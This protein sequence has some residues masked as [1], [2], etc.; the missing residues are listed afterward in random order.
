MDNLTAGSTFEARVAQLLRSSTG[1]KNIREQQHIRGMNV[2][3]IF[4]KQWN[5]HRYLTI[6]V[7]CKNWKKGL[8]RQALKSIYFDYEPLIQNKDIDELWIITPRPVGATVQEHANKHDKLVILHINELEQDII[9]FTIYATYLQNRFLG[10]ALSSY[11]VPS[12]IEPGTQ[13][14]HGEISRWLKSTVSTPIAIWAGYGMGKTSYAAFLASELAAQF[15]ADSTNRIPILIPLGDYYTAPRIEG[16]FASVLTRDKG[17]HGYNF[18]TFWN[19]HEA[20]RF[21]IILDGF[22]EMKHAMNKSE[23]SAITKEIRRLIL[24][25]SKVLL[26]GRPDVIISDEEHKELVRGT[27]YASDIEI[28]DNLSV[29]FDELRISFFNRDEYLLFINKYMS[30]FYKQKDK[31]SFV[32][33]RIAEIEQLDLE[34]IIRR[35]VQAR[36]LAQILLNPKKSVATLSKY[37]LY[38]VFIEECLTREIEKPERRKTEQD[39]RRKF[40]QDLAWWLW[41]FKRTRTFTVDDIPEP[42]LAPYISETADPVGQMRELLV[43]SVIEER[44]VGS[45]LNEKDAGTFYFPHLSF[46]EFL[47]AEYLITRDLK[48]EDYDALPESIGGEIRSFLRSYKKEDALYRLS[49]EIMHVL[50]AHPW[51]LRRG[52]SL[53]VLTLIAESP[54]LNRQ[55]A[56][57]AKNPLSFQIDRKG[58]LGLWQ[59]ASNLAVLLHTGRH[60]AILSACLNAVGIMEIDFAVLAIQFVVIAMFG[61]SNEISNP[62]ATAVMLAALLSGIRLDKLY[63]AIRG[64]D[65][66]YTIAS[67]TEDYCVSVLTHVSL[68]KDRSTFVFDVAKIYRPIFERPIIFAKRNHQNAM[69]VHVKAADVREHLRDNKA[70]HHFDRWIGAM[71]SLDSRTIFEPGPTQRKPW[72][73]ARTAR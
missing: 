16:L 71:R 57:I 65:S 32:R 3:I 51:R 61:D 38:T 63:H 54:T 15:L 46:T 59:L 72:E 68:S 5:P 31:Q 23:F 14:L 70:R 73:P 47:V 12:R 1:Y 43:G 28:S 17:V 20:G 27:R 53:E 18:N 29:L 10:D 42:L 69:E 67:D 50:G 41:A 4:E 48:E 21:V 34:D 2:D 9:D 19:L 64:D 35:P 60:D 6:A 44:S 13:T 33:K 55:A 7:E 30:H 8:D 24:S 11:Y 66:K 45:L 62:K 40:M 56:I 52:F 49:Q 58:P 37:D 36:M 25:N 26:L 39:T 22:D